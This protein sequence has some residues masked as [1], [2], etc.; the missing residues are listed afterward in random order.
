MSLVSIMGCTVTCVLGNRLEIKLFIKGWWIVCW[1]FKQHRLQKQNDS[2]CIAS[3][4]PDITLFSVFNVVVM[5]I[6]NLEEKSYSWHMNKTLLFC[7][8]G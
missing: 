4:K 6:Q 2:S 7:T 1:K 3:S 5:W 8:K